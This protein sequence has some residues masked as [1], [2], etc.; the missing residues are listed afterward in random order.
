MS[1]DKEPKNSPEPAESGNQS[2]VD[3]HIE[4][5]ITPSPDSWI[6]ESQADQGS[7]R[8]G[9]EIPP[10]PPDKTKDKK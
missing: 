5:K 7:I 3:I 1:E 8:K 10:P 9:S 6:G 4:I 2:K